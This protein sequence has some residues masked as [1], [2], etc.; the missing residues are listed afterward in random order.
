MSECSSEKAG[1]ARIEIYCLATA[2]PAFSLTPFLTTLWSRNHRS[3]VHWLTFD[4]IGRDFI[5]AE[6]VVRRLIILVLVCHCGT[7][8]GLLASDRL[9][10]IVYDWFSTAAACP[11]FLSS[12][13]FWLFSGRHWWE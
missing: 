9:V 5:A 1:F 7:V 4:P 12:C 2:L 6:R 11:A 8:A 10:V 3:R 13:W